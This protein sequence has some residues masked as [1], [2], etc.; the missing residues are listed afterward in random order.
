MQQYAALMAVH[1][2]SLPLIQVL[3]IVILPEEMLDEFEDAALAD[4][5]VDAVVEAAELELVAADAYITKKLRAT[6]VKM[7]LIMLDCI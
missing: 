5:D 4:D 1:V 6:T 7:V 2:V 3:P